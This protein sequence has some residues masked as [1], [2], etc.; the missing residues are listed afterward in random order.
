MNNTTLKATLTDKLKTNHPTTLL[1]TSESD[2]LSVSFSP[3]VKLLCAQWLKPMTSEEYRQSVRMT[4]RSIAFLRAELILIDASVL[5]S[6]SEEDQVWTANFLRNAL[7]KTSIK[8]SARVISAAGFQPEAMQNVVSRSGEMPYQIGLFY[9]AE[10]A[11]SWLLDGHDEKMT[12]EVRI[13]VPLNFNLK[14]LRREVLT[15]AVEQPAQ[16]P[17]T[18]HQANAST[19]ALPD[20]L[21]LRTDFVSISLSHEENLMSIRWKKPPVSRQYRFGMLKAGRALM[22]QKLERVL[23]NNQRLGVLTLEDQGWLVTTSIELLPRTSLKKLAVVTSADALQ[24]MSSEAIGFKLKE[25]NLPYEARY[26]LSV[27]EARE[28]L[29]A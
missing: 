10:K 25:A 5:I 24:Q 12:E 27:D 2:I 14:L 23:L 22:E 17:D 15:K 11:M 1:N 8:K 6:I 20:K 21:S 29:M 28:W 18:K 7:S 26:F 19:A 4:A 16:N 3:D 13:K 9:D